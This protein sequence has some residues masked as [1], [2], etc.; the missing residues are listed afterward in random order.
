MSI[1]HMSVKAGTLRPLTPTERTALRMFSERAQT[2][3]ALSPTETGL[4][5]HIMDAVQPLR[6]MLISGGFHDY[7]HQRQGVI[8]RVEGRR[9]SARGH[10]HA[11]RI[12]LYRPVT[13]AGDPR[14]WFQRAP[15]WC[16]P[17]DMLGIFLLNGILHVVNLSTFDPEPTAYRKL[18]RQLETLTVAE[19]EGS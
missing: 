13:K 10:I 6:D 2:V 4:K 17:G 11:I 1:S 7:G 3:V 18:C 16:K 5:K 8:R 19:K 14:V 12:S 15:E 9:I